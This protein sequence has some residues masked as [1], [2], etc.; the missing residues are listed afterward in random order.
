MIQ[1]ILDMVP[2]IC[3]SITT[4]IF[5]TFTSLQEEAVYPLAVVPNPYPLNPRPP[6]TFC[7]YRFAYS[8]HFI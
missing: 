2:K 8:G 7:L 1:W 6:V 5:K 4:V 3:A